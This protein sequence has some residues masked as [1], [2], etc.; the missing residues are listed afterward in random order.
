[1]ELERTG[2]LIAQARKGRNEN[3]ISGQ[4]KILLSDIYFW[5]LNFSVSN[6]YRKRRGNET[7]FPA[8]Y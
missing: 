6:Q 2:A 8:F 5:L 7:T 4:S 3:H 1:M